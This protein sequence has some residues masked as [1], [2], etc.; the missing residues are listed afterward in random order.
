VPPRFAFGAGPRICVGN[1]F[2]LTELML[3]VAGMV[4]SF[5]V[6]L[7]PHRPVMPV[8]VVA[9]TRSSAAI[10]AGVPLL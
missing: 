6:G 10:L 8:G 7:A 1:P 5:Y 4:R 2:A 9:F 3:V